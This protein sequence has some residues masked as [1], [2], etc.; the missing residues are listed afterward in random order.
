MAN[1][2]DRNDGQRRVDHWHQSGQ[3]YLAERGHFYLAVTIIVSPKYTRRVL[4]NMKRRVGRAGRFIPRFCFHA[5][6]SAVSR[7]SGR[8]SSFGPPNKNGTHPEP[9]RNPVRGYRII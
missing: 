6:R 8:N 2:P 5:L 9:A 3:F 7:V 4:S 1:L